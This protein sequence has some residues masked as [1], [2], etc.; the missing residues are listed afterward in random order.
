ME[1]LKVPVE[2]LGF[3]EPLNMEERGRLFSAML[4]YARD[5][6]VPAE[7]E[8]ER[9]LWP[10]ARREIDRVRE[11]HLRRCAVNAANGRKGGRPK[12]AAEPSADDSAP[13]G[14]QAGACPEA[15]HPE[16]RQAA[17]PLSEAPAALE[18]PSVRQKDPG[19]DGEKPS[20]PNR[21][22]R[23]P[24]RL[25]KVDLTAVVDDEYPAAETRRAPM[26]AA[27]PPVR[28]SG[29]KP[30]PPPAPEPPEEPPVPETDREPVPE[31]AAALPLLTGEDYIIHGR[32]I[33]EWIWAYPDVDVPQELQ[34]MRGWFLKNPSKRRNSRD[35]IPFV[36][37]WLNRVQR[38]CPRRKEAVLPPPEEWSF[39][40]DEIRQLMLKNSGG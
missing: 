35:L 11:Q 14:N 3:V 21:P 2:F 26:R 6:T 24:G 22:G 17:K 23:V 13:E 4:A 5:E 40:L 10:V 32:K 20:R 37:R 12:K 34:K 33:R 9:F 8:N 16:E 15:P 25:G 30:A 38:S 19:A 28:A 27:D 7:M 18:N 29:E 36:L 1:W 39:S 31:G